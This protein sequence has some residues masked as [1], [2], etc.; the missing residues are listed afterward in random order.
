MT[1]C[2]SVWHVDLVFLF[3]STYSTDENLVVSPLLGNV[4]FAS[5]QYSICFTLGSFAKIYSDTYGKTTCNCM[6]KQWNGILS[7]HLKKFVKLLTNF[8]CRLQETSTIM[9]LLR[10]FGETFISTPKREWLIRIKTEDFMQSSSSAFLKF[11]RFVSFSFCPAANSQR[12]LPAVTLSAASWNLSWNLFTRS[13]HRLDTSDL[14]G[15]SV[16]EPSVCRPHQVPLFVCRWLGTWTRL[17]PESWM[18]WGSTWL[19]RNW[20]WTSDLCW[21]WSATASLENSLVC[22][23]LSLSLFPFVLLYCGVL[24]L[25]KVALQAISTVLQL[26]IVLIWW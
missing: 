9:S 8:A 23:S 1:S 12:R 20:S 26:F 17:S 11:L 15:V 21:G 16:F 2:D 24:L 18:S 4:C 22:L 5:S 3:L 14:F 7:S 10:G 19:K 6:Y 25:Y 13:S